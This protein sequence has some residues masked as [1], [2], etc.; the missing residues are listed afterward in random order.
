MNSMGKHKNLYMKKIKCVIDIVISFLSLILLSPVFAGLALAVFIDDPGPIFFSQKRIG[1]DKSLFRL[2]KF[3]SMKISTPHDVPTHQLDDPE[4][5]ITRVGKFLRKSS[6]DELPQ[7]WDILCGRMSFIGPRPALWN[8]YD[9]I[10]ERDKYGANDVKPG[11]TGLAQIKGR[12]ELTIYEKARLD[13]EYVQCLKAGGIKALLIDLKCFIGTIF[14]VVTSK[15]VVEG[16]ERM[17]STR[18][19]ENQDVVDSELDDYGY[20]KKFNIDTNATKR[21]LITGVNSYIGDNLKRWAEEYYDNNLTVDMIDM[22]DGTWREKSFRNYDV[23]F[24]VA[25]IAHVDIRAIDRKG[26]EDYYKINTELAIETAKKAKREG[27]RQFI[28]MSSM[29][30]YGE[31]KNYRKQFIIDEHTTPN[32]SNIYGDSKWQADKRVRY[33]ADSDFHVAVL[34]APM[35]YGKDSKGNYPVLA[36]IARMI[37]FF[38]DIKNIRSMLYIDNLCEFLCKLILSGEGGI[39]FPQNAEYTKTSFMTEM[40]AKAAHKKI[41]ITYMLN[42]AVWVL[43]KIPGS[44][45][46][47]V[48][49]AFGNMAYRQ[50]LSR[51]EGLDYRICTLEE[52]VKKIEGIK[53]K[54]DIRTIDKEYKGK[55]LVVASVASMIEQFNIPNIQLLQS[56]GYDVDVAANFLKG[57]TCTYTQLENLYKFLDSIKVD[58]YQIDFSRDITDIRSIVMAIKQ[59]NSVMTGKAKPINKIRYHKNEEKYLFVHCHSPIGGVIGRIA[60]KKNNVKSIYTAHGFHFYKGAPFKNWLIFFPVEKLLSRITDILITINHED[61]KRAKRRFKAGNIIYI[62]GIG[63]D[64]ERFNNPSTDVEAKRGELGLGE[65]DIMLF[66]VGELSKRKNHEV[67]IRALGEIKNPRLHY[68][69][70]GVGDL[71]ADYRKIVKAMH[72]DRNIHFLGYRTDISELCKATD[73]FIFPSVQEGLPVA[74]MEAIA[75]RTP[76]ICSKIRGNMDLIKSRKCLFDPENV[77]SVVKCIEDNIEGGD[78]NLIFA[79]MRSETESN[80]ERLLKY[81]LKIVKS[82]M[83]KIYKDIV[84][85]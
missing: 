2:H 9:L 50:Y 85:Y 55:V 62:P 17:M 27:V 78:R 43:A 26:R 14:S 57:N 29:V 25:G 47:I 41:C 79:T 12:D 38:P 73:I 8:Q 37:P 15:G 75:C 36:K 71:Q 66:S 28:F 40:I 19:I 4:Q 70:A 24:H 30:I 83:Y 22:I 31:T 13:G 81:D 74:L 42:P 53:A 54:K 7:L 6:L 1:K 45:S 64:V 46:R 52:S 11:L 10:E 59:L 63:I 32:P 69:V 39:Y 34:R 61:Y 58:L 35:I 76:V 67:V 77:D 20:K 68:F 5:Y 21:V 33:L 3:R 23:V 56:I 72:L 84:W 16:S 60:A 48:N 18:E 51:Y 49:K 80:Y 65:E 44:L 82:K